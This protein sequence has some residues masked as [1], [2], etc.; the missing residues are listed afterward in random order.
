M[1]C[2]E[3]SVQVSVP[4]VFRSLEEL[5]IVDALRNY[6]DHQHPIDPELFTFPFNF[7][8]IEVGKTNFVRKDTGIFERL[9]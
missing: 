7:C 4:G 6:T 2:D 3:L 5:G 8:P 1:G 9:L